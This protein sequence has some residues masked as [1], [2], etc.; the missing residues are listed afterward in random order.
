MRALF[1]ATAVTLM[2]AGCSWLPRLGVYK[3][4]V[5]QG[6]YVTQ[7]QVDKLKVGSDAT[8]GTRRHWN[9]DADGPL[10]RRSLGLSLPIRQARA[11]AGAPAVHGLLRE[12]QACA[13]GRRRDAAA[14]SGSRAQP[15]V[16]TRC[17]TSPYRRRPRPA[18]K[19]GCSSS[20]ER[21]VCGSTRRSAAG[22][23]GDRRQRRP[24]G[25]GA[26]RRGARCARSDPFGRAGDLRKRAAGQGRGR[27]LRPGHGRERSR[28]MSRPAFRVPT[29]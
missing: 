3:L 26:D 19:T 22:S 24:D 27:A 14:A 21:W 11:D 15:G 2:L 12:R 16:E 29:C 23:R 13:L 9:A 18:T 17:S 7:D 10:P 5:N 25:A 6:N 20:S 4:D 8:T 1:C 28:Q